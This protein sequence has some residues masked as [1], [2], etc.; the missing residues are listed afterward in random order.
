MASVKLEHIYVDY[1]QTEVLKDISFEAADKA[2]C[3]I[4][5]PSGCGKTVTLRT[6][7]GLTRPHSG[8][9]YFN[10]QLI[11]HVAPGDRDVAMAFQTY[12]LYPT[13]TV[14]E[15]WE[16][17][18]RATRRSESLI[19]ERI[20]Q[21]TELL[22]MA[23]LLKRYPRELSGGQQQRVALGRA[24]VRRPEVLL[25]DEPMGNLDA[26]LRVELRASLK[27]LQMD[28]GLTTVYVTHDQIEAQAVGDKI[29]V[30]DVG[31]VQ[32]TGS[33]EEIYEQPANLF[34]AS[35]IGIPR[36]NFLD[37]RLQQENGTL[38]VEHPLFQITMPAE[39]KQP[40]LEGASGDSVVVGIRPETI[41]ISQQGS[42]STGIPGAIYVTE[43]QSNEVIV[44]VELED[45]TLVRI[46]AD[47]DG[48]G[49]EPAIKQPVFLD[50][51][52]HTVHIF[53]SATERR[54]SQ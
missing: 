10:A 35:F 37:G 50:I 39:K 19:R 30:M 17:P 42:G 31:S 21:V 16:F 5:G 6:I 54:I 7:A 53:D 27:K 14:Q 11:D 24:L 12:A 3:V 15:N 44:G 28:S 9:V 40:V 20:G 52:P 13:M 49:F 18:L 25:L 38:W 41:K 51:D 29:I 2:L 46:R 26:K 32:Q 47:R 4:V 23:P 33:P 8:H 36:M 1:G 43:P 48:L 34:V 45:K 22:G